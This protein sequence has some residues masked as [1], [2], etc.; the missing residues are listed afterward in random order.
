MSG[1]SAY[2]QPYRVLF[3]V[4]PEIHENNIKILVQS[5]LKPAWNTTSERTKGIVKIGTKE[6]FPQ[7]RCG[8]LYRFRLRVNPV[9]RR[10]GKRLGLIRDDALVDWLKKK[11]EQ[12]GASF[13]SVLVIDEGYFTGIREKDRINI[14]MV[15]FEGILKVIDPNRFYETFN[16][17]IGHAK[18][19]GCGLLSLA[20]EA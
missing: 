19:F 11:E 4:E 16:H 9:I 2:N 14:K 8:N 6:F 15:R 7:F 17:G 20:R 10:N 1:F 12:I 3:R 18:G 5:T 13:S